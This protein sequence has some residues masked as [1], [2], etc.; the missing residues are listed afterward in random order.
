MGQG[1]HDAIGPGGVHLTQDIGGS[2]APA[3]A[4]CGAGRPPSACWAKPASIE[5]H[6]LAHDP[7]NVWF[8][9]RKD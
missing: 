4:R 2:A 9:S 6:V 1:L 5:R 3:S 7:M 8:V